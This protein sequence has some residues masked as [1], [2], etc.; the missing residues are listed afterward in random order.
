MQIARQLAGTLPRLR[1]GVPARAVRHRVTSLAAPAGLGH[2]AS[3]GERWPRNRRRVGLT[4]RTRSGDRS[5]CPD[6]DGPVSAP[7]LVGLGKRVGIRMRAVT[8][9]WVT[10][11]IGGGS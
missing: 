11:V 2:T 6:A 7:A 5:G 1:R 3:D 9:R 8:A 4:A 10:Y